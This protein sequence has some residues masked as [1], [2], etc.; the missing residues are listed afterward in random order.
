MKGKAHKD[1]AQRL[2]ALPYIFKKEGTEKPIW[3]HAVSV[4]EVLAVKDF[5]TN[6]RAQFPKRK[7]VFSTTTRTGNEMAK[8]VLSADILKFYFP[9]DFSFVVKRVLDIVRPSAF[10]MMET[11]IWPNLILELYK[12]KIPSV[13]IN[14]R[15]SERSF[16][17]YRKIKF[18]F[19]S[20]LKRITLFCMQ[21]EDDAMRI[22]ALGAPEENVKV[23]GNM[24]FDTENMKKGEE[25]L[26]KTDLGFDESCELFLAG[27]THRGEEEIIF[28]TYAALRKEFTNLALL[29]APRHIE[30]AGYI[31]KLA[32]MKG[33]HAVLRSETK[34]LPA[35]DTFPKKAVLIL[36]SFGELRDIYA[37]ADIVFMGGSLVKR[38]GHNIIEPALFSKPVIFGPHMSNF[39][40]MARSFIE[41]KAA[42]EVKR[43]EEL[44]GTLGGLMRDKARMSAVGVSA[45]RLIEKNKGATRF[46][47]SELGRLLSLEGDRQR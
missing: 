5:V 13:L 9:L 23:T 30:R 28:D 42:I 36:D 2:G 8:K 35:G 26:S 4:G 1:F 33:L 15:I 17:G 43:K 10:I 32:G 12:R 38:G 47:I 7:V 41:E 11:E 31:K 21:T 37:L 27:S 24:K 45:R 14:G 6:L 16:V 34:G 29:V 46:N 44:Y 39:R 22:K 20:I 3:I 40:N 18:F 25:D 19:G